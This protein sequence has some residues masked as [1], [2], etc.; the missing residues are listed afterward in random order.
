MTTGWIREN[1]LRISA[2]GIGASVVAG[3]IYTLL[4]TKPKQAQRTDKVTSQAVVKFLAKQ[5]IPKIELKDDRVEDEDL[6]LMFMQ[7]KADMEEKQKELDEEAKKAGEAILSKMLTSEEER[8]KYVEQFYREEEETQNLLKGALQQHDIDLPTMQKSISVMESEK[9]LEKMKDE[10]FDFMKLDD[11]L[12]FD[13]ARYGQEFHKQLSEAQPD[14][15]PQIRRQA[16]IDAAAD[17]Y[18]VDAHD[19]ELSIKESP[20]INDPKLKTFMDQID[21]ETTKK[22]LL[23]AFAR[24]LVR[25]STVIR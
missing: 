15:P 11:D 5:I 10:G 17:K 19:I 16:S 4:T 22:S 1:Y 6:A 14:M 8:K 9:V 12:L 20:S 13:I 3:I 7:A 23:P 24:S 25:R 18:G 21:D 2:I